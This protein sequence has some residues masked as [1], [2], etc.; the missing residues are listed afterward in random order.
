MNEIVLE[1]TKE[2][3]RRTLEGEGSG[4]DWWHIYRV[5]KNAI[6]IAKNEQADLFV[7]EL[8]AL[9]HDIADWKFHPDDDAGPKVARQW[10]ES[11]NVHEEVIKK[12]CSVIAEVS[13]KGAHVTSTASSKEAMIVQDADKLDAIGALGIAR[14]FMYSGHVGKILYDPAIKPTLHTSFEE[15]KKAAGAEN[16]AINHFYEK[17]LLLKS[18]MHT[19]TARKMAQERHEFMERYLEQFYGEWEGKL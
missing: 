17:L 6:N 19:E 13:F 1:T 2:Y 15:Y 3:V 18:R 5:W 14:C 11:I 4:H 7:V 12:V 16:P 8:A 9:L 10:L